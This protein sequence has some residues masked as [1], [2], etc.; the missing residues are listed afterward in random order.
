MSKVLDAQPA[1]SSTAV[2][3]PSSVTL[4]V[5]P[6]RERVNALSSGDR[7]HYRNTGEFPED[8]LTQT[9][10][11]SPAPET[12]QSTGPSPDAENGPDAASGEDQ[13]EPAPIAGKPRRNE[14]NEQRFELL[15][16]H[17]AELKARVA[18]LEKTLAE[19]TAPKTPSVETPKPDGLKKPRLS[20]YPGT[21]EGI[22]KYEDDQEAYFDA[23]NEA[24]FNREKNAQ[25]TEKAN[26][27]WGDRVKA[28]EAK[29]PVNTEKPDGRD[30]QSVISK[31]KVTPVMNQEILAH[32]NGAELSYWLGLPE[33][34]DEMADF[35]KRTHVGGMSGEQLQSACAKN[36]A[37]RDQALIALG[38]A[39]AELDRINRSLNKA[40]TT[41][42]P[43]DRIGGRHRP[44][45]EVQVPARGTAIG[46]PIEDALK[47]RDTKTYIKL[48]NEK[49][50]RELA[51]R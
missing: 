5:N 40:P 2:P 44:S 22:A 48:M 3:A 33:N 28:A 19:G 30:Y 24:R 51:A 36:P 34:A 20:D 37:I 10:D 27:T 18:L 8:K 23:K 21:P 6:I 12:T 14:K 49:E 17:N 26:Q 39:K 16:S 46:D 41:P 4:P 42:E 13:S 7:E 9:A 38:V 15:T 1:A 11:P 35:I 45:S 25:Q 29:H 43:K 50:R 47:R 31:L 32:E